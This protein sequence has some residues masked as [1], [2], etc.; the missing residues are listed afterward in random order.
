MLT[1]QLLN[2]EGLCRTFSFAGWRLSTVT[3]ISVQYSLCT[4]QGQ[5]R[6][7]AVRGQHGTVGRLDGETLIKYV[8]V[9]D[10]RIS[11]TV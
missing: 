9:P 8:P 10:F 7:V 11:L 6:T 1:V 3:I 5:D 2:G 4:V